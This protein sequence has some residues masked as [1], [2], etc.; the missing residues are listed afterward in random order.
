MAVT[1]WT[2]GY[3]ILTE[4]KQILVLCT[5][6]VPLLDKEVKRIKNLLL[7]LLF[8]ANTTKE[9]KKVRKKEE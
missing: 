5:G 6:I 9:S 3:Q 8:H 1:E 2:T 7:R 4:N